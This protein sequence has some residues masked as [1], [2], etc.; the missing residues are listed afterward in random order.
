MNVPLEPL[1]CSV[2]GRKDNYNIVISP[3]DKR[4]VCRSC[5]HEKIVERYRQAVMAT[6]ITP[7]WKRDTANNLLF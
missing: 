3:Y 4:L 7:I 6:D 5:R 1:T 2:C